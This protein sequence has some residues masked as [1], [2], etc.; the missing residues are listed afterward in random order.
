MPFST[1]PFQDAEEVPPHLSR[2]R[3][4]HHHYW[5]DVRLQ[6]AHQDSR[7]PLER[8]QDVMARSP[9]NRPCALARASSKAAT[10][11]PSTAPFLGLL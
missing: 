11:A 10:A 3:P 7:W 1:H 5:Q 2:D 8:G 6:G 9:R 4:R